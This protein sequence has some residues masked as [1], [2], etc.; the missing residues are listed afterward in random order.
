[1]Y[2]YDLKNHVYKNFTI[3]EAAQGILSVNNFKKSNT[4]FT[5]VGGFKSHIKQNSAERIKNAFKSIHNS[6]LIIIDHSEYTHA[7]DGY[8]TS[9]ERSV[10]HVPSIGKKLGE[11]LA[12]LKKGGVSGKIHCIGHSLGGQILGHVGEK[13]KE[14]TGQKISRLTALDPAGP[15]FDSKK[16]EHNIRFGLADY[17]EIYHCNAGLLGSDKTYGDVDFFVN[18]GM[19]QPVCGK[20]STPCGNLESSKCSHK[21]C[22]AMWTASVPNYNWYP[23]YDCRNFKKYNRAKLSSCRKTTAG[24]WNPGT[25]KGK[26]YLSTEGYNFD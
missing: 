23:A 4:L 24:F 20:H 2:F 18:N 8:K 25:A 14:L 16:K 21:T 6:Y 7:N 13:F 1:M 19:Y 12:S 10:K 17:V 3:E 26:Y 9:Y 15:C 5:Y 22:V 11:M